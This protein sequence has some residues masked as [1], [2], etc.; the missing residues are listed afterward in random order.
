MREG[1]E[2]GAVICVTRVEV[3]TCVH[4]TMAGDGSCLGE[5][6]GGHGDQDGRETHSS[7][8]SL[9]FCWNVLSVP[10]SFKISYAEL[11]IMG[12]FLC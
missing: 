12:A 6:T 1:E 11:V 8:Y 3:V 10:N 5:G 2:Q 7:P 4:A 9:L